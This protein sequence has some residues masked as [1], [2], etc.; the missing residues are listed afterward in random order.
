MSTCKIHVIEWFYDI[1]LDGTI[2]IDKLMYILSIRI[3]RYDILQ[4]FRDL[5]EQISPYSILFFGNNIIFI[6]VNK[7]LI[8]KNDNYNIPSTI[9]FNKITNPFIYY[10]ELM[11]KYNSKVELYDI[12]FDVNYKLIEPEYNPHYIPSKVYNLCNRNNLYKVDKWLDVCM[13]NHDID[14]LKGIYKNFNFNILRYGDILYLDDQFIYFYVGSRFLVRCEVERKL[15]IPFK[16]LEITGLK[17][18]IDIIKCNE[19]ASIELPNGMGRAD[20]VFG[21]ETEADLFLRFVV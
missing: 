20:I 3:I 13:F 9:S 17:T 4:E 18:Y 19:G 16:I 10:K 5:I 2:T 21:D 7:E 1:N 12:L 8:C 14:F 6:G 15:Y 11:N